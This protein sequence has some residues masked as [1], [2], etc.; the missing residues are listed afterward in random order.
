MLVG[1]ILDEVRL[2]GVRLRRRQDEIARGCGQSRG[3][4]HV[5]EAAQGGGRSV[6]QLARKLGQTR[7][8]VQRIADGLV[9]NGLATYESNPDH[10]RSPFLQLSEHGRSA[11]RALQRE[12][13][14]RAPGVEQDLET[15][16]HET[17]LQVLRALREAL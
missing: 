17:V 1:R 12:A 11:L 3:A 7:Q 8:G 2:L 16:D 6:A 13:D 4:W 9:D 14:A 5:L 10:R 15:E